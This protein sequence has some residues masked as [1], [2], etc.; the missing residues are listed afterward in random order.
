LDQTTEYLI[1]TAKG[2]VTDPAQVSIQQEQQEENSQ[3][4]FALLPPGFQASQGRKTSS[5]RLSIPKVVIGE[6]II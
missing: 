5:S 1:W 6:R 3:Y 4:Y 2:M